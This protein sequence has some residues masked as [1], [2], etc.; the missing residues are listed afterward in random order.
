MFYLP[1]RGFSQ[2]SHEEH[3]AGIRRALNWCR[4]NPEE[5]KDA[6][7]NEW[8]AMAPL[9][10]VKRPFDAVLTKATE[11]ISSSSLIVM[12]GK[13]LVDSSQ[14][15]S[16]CIFVVGGN[17]LGRGVTF[18][19]LETIYYTR[20]AKKPQADTMWQHSRI[21]GYDRD[22]GLVQVFITEK[23]YYL[24][25]E[26]NAVNDALINQVKNGI[27]GIHFTYNDGV[28]PTRKNVIDTKNVLV[29]PGGHNYF[30]DDPSND[31]KADIDALLSDLSDDVPSY[32]ASLAVMRRILLHI[33]SDDAFD[34]AGYV[35][36]L[37]SIL[38]EDPTA[39]GVLIVRRHRNDGRKRAVY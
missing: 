4:T 32:P 26:I 17:S 29:I 12:N 16:G 33:K 38:A 11:L 15:S 8:N 5:F 6:V 28:N 39:R 30:P 36:Y 10:S 35:D 21:F 14:Y 23:L 25:R 31:T 3:A 18:P 37:N 9:K 19:S 22:P 20:T 27:D 13:Y 1:P 7:Q 2:K 34:P 24:F